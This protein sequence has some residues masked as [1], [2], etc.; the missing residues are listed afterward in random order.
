LRQKNK[1]EKS[2]ESKYHQLEENHW[3]FMA[4]RNIIISF[5]KIFPKNIEILD[6]GCSGGALIKQ[7]SNEGYFKC[8]GI[9]VSKKAINLAKSRGIENCYLMDGGK[10]KFKK[11]FDL[12]IAS[13][14]LEHI[15]N[16]KKAVQFWKNS[17]KKNGRIICFVPA[18]KFL[19]SKHDVANQHYRRYSNLMLASLF[20]SENMKID[21]ISYWNFFLFFP[22]SF[23]RVIQERIIKNKK[24]RHHLKE[25]NRVANSILY[26]LLIIENSILKQFNLPVGVSLFLIARNIN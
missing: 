8:T 14:V 2:F 17:L 18:F 12:I 20:L 23:I 19:W 24:S 3:W 1:M 9:D 4:R 25:S 26:N 7:L 22:I 5:V 10:V 16:D 21:R 15:K 6:I 11:K 13:D